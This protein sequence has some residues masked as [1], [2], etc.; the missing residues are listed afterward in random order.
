MTACTEHNDI[1][2]EALNTCSYSI[3]T[4]VLNIVNGLSFQTP[5][6][7]IPNECEESALK[8]RATIKID[9]KFK[10]LEQ[11]TPNKLKKNISIKKKVKKR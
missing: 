5:S 7:V 6:H 4:K 2:R 11:F 3:N 8:C 9:L 10:T 1:W